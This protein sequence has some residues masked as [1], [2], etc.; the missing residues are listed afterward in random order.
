MRTEAFEHIAHSHTLLAVALGGVVATM[1]ALGA[2]LFERRLLRKERERDGA[3][4][5]GELLSALVRYINLSHGAHGRGDPFGS[6][7]IRMLRSVRREV[8]IYERNREG[9]ILLRDSPLR[10]E[11]HGLMARL[12]FALERILDTTDALVV[13]TDDAVREE[14][15]RSRDFAYEFLMECASQ[16]PPLIAKL[17]KLAKVKFA[18]FTEAAALGSAAAPG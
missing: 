6:I 1:S 12:T 8:E 7:T 9:L 2:T 3:M 5:F 10:V 4:M 16:T 11:I 17:E 13:E 15:I 18:P 14:M